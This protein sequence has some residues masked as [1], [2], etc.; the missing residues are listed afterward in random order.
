[1]VG[2][3][4]PNW[5]VYEALQEALRGRGDVTA[6]DDGTWQVSL[7]DARYRAVW[8]R[9]GWTPE[10]RDLLARVPAIDIVVGP[11]ISPG[12]RDL[13]RDSGKSWIEAKTGA[14]HL[15]LPTMYVEQPGHPE[16]RPAVGEAWTPAA[17]SVAEALLTGT[18]ATVEQVVKRT[19]V[20]VGTAGRVLS[21][22]TA[23]GLL[24]APVARGR[25]SGRILAD[26]H[27]FLEQYSTAVT[28]MP[29]VSLRA[30]VFW[31]HPADDLLE[32]APLLD[33]SGI[34]WAATGPLAAD[35]MAPYLTQPTPLRI[36][37]DYRSPVGLQVAARAIDARVSPG[38]RL[39]LEVLRSHHSAQLFSVVRGISCAPWPRVY[40]DLRTSGVRGE[41]AAEHLREVYERRNGVSGD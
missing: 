34:R 30:A 2:T 29:T 31:Q 33:H 22:W 16:P 20:A 28:G 40:A 6:G 15:D 7:D 37:I 8:C 32:A 35:V 5:R 27:E 9:Y 1:V 36:L 14:V 11:T 41:E 24:S 3:V 23:S 25:H 39:S 19:G 4:N 26:R 17:L 12:A 18:P 38:G 21:R 10:V 13:L